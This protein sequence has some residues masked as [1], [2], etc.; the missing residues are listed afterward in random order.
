MFQRFFNNPL[1]NRILVVL[2]LDKYL[3]R[4]NNYW[5]KYET[6]LNK[7]HQE[8]AGYSHSKD[9]QETV[10]QT[11]LM[12][13][14]TFKT[15]ISANA[16]VLDIGCG[17]GL[18]LMDFPKSM[19]LFGIDLSEKML[20]LARTNCSDATLIN[21]EFLKHDFNTKFDLIYSIGV[22]QYIPKSELETFFKKNS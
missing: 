1:I 8:I 12:L 6:N 22:L 20:S 7:S 13:N 2:R 17:P 15:Y 10:D 4:A 3:Q 18:Y 16:T 19:R 5:E 21:G 9:V 14:Q 11:H